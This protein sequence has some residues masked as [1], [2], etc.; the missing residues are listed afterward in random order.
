MKHFIL[1]ILFGFFIVINADVKVEEKQTLNEYK[2]EQQQKSIDELKAEIKELKKEIDD[3]K[4]KK[5]ENK[6][7]NE[8][9]DKR[10]GDINLNIT[11]FA[12]FITV[13]LLGFGFFGYRNAKAD[14]K[15][16]AE[17]TTKNWLEKDGKEK[18]S[19]M[20]TTLEQKA[21]KEISI[22]V[23]NAKDELKQQSKAEELLMQGNSHFYNKEYLKAEEY[24]KKAI[25]AGNNDALNNLGNLYKEQK[26]YS[27]AEEYYKKAIDAGV[28]DALINLGILYKE[29]KEYSKAEEYYKKAVDAGNNDALFNLGILYKEQK[30]YS[31]AE[32]YYKK[33]IDG[34]NN[35]A[36]NNLGVLYQE[37][38]EYSKAEE[39]YK[40]AIDAG[41]N[42]ALNNLA[43]LYFSQSENK[44]KALEFVNKSYEIKKA[45]ANTHT[46]ATILLWNEEF[47]KSYEKFEEWME[48]EGALENL[49]DIS[50]YLNLLISKAQYYKAKEY[51]ENEKYQLKDKLKPIWYALM[52]LMQDEFPNEIKK[53]GSE[54][55]TS[56]DD[57]L[58]TIEELKQKY[59]I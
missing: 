48:Y 34:G 33:A 25:D 8:S 35:D 53:M 13:L 22:A 52:T 40:K 5:L 6:K 58:K 11:I 14:A 54:L 32:E 44:E 49:N 20:I 46:L 30:E 9:L 57:I 42:D 24:Y 18:L 41:N 16:E 39:C 12:I 21:Q 3:T 19:E 17:D 59:K 38:K 56:V 43:Y 27:K 26:E 15:K 7:D 4:E 31:K 55:Q 2:I 28:N 45:Y 23:Q 10:I 47:T 29:Q 36:L 1:L 37:Q 50:E 51:F